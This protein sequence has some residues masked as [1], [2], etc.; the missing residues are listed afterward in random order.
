MQKANGGTLHVCNQHDQKPM[1]IS[2]RP[3]ANGTVLRSTVQPPL[4]LYDITRIGWLVN[5]QLG[6]G[7][8]GRDCELPRPL[9]TILS[10]TSTTTGWHNYCWG[11]SGAQIH[12]T[13]RP[14][15]LLGL[16]QEPNPLGRR[17]GPINPQPN[18]IANP[19]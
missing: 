16:E 8:Q 19:S 11:A 6:F 7:R 4:F 9:F 1:N 3:A 18:R 15:C 10:H 14:R 13:P 17:Q 2:S 5:G 12:T